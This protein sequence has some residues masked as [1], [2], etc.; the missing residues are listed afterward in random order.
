MTFLCLFFYIGSFAFGATA[1]LIGDRWNL[2]FLAE[3]ERQVELHLEKHLEL[4]PDTDTQS[5]AVI[6]Q[7]REDEANHATTA[8]RAG[9]AE[10]PALV[11][12]FMRFTSRAMT[13]ATR[14]L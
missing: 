5:R 14:W 9:A 1:G 13:T 2:G 12:N 6:Q 4:L 3:T 11:K 7:M 10:L 8:I